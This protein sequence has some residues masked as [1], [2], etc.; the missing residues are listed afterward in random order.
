VLRRK[1]AR[2][3]K[4]ATALAAA[5]TAAIL[6]GTS[7]AARPQNRP[8][9]PPATVTQ[10]PPRLVPSPFIPVPRSGFRWHEAVVTAYTAGPAS[11]G[12]R[13]GDPGY[14]LTFVGL[15]VHTGVAAVDPTV[16]PLG[17]ILYV[18]GYGLAAA[19]DTG[20]A[21]Q[22]WHVDVFL[23]DAAAAHAWG[24]RLLRVGVLRPQTPFL[25]RRDA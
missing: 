10:P 11:T 9:T 17:S 19:L 25:N 3:A 7:V 18:P 16:I 5:S 13:P 21:V 14:G 2:P 24:R 4:L 12:K 23:L 1:R 20:S 15:P 6:I 22:G 8:A